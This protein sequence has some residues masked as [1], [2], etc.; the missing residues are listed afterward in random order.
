VRTLVLLVLLTGTAA[1]A[2]LS[3]AL[4]ETLERHGSTDMI[5]VWT[6]WEEAPTASDLFRLEVRGARARARS[7]WL[8]GISVQVPV[9]CVSELARVEGIRSLDRVMTGLV[10]EDAGS[11]LPRD[12]RT[13]GGM[14]F[15]YG[16]G[17]EQITVV[18]AD[19]V[20][21]EGF[22]GSGVTLG[23]FDTGY[24]STHPSISHLWERGAIAGAH[25][26]NS[27]DHIMTPFGALL[28]PFSGARYVNSLSAAEDLD[29][30]VVAFSVAS[31]ESI[32]GSSIRPRNK[33][34]M[35]YACDTSGLGFFETFRIAPGDSFAIQPFA[36]LSGDTLL[37]AWQSVVPG[38]GIDVQFARLALG[39]SMAQAT[40]LS[41][42]PEDAVDPAVVVHGD[43]VWVFWCSE[44]GVFVRRSTDFG[45]SYEP[46]QTALDRHGDPL[47][48]HASSAESVLMAA[49]SLGDSLVFLR[50]EDGGLV[51]EAKTLGSG[52]LPHFV[53]VDSTVHLIATHEDDLIYHRSD[54]LGETFTSLGTV[55]SET[56]PTV[57]KLRQEGSALHLV[58][59]S[60]G[61][62]LLEAPLSPDGSI[63]LVDILD[64]IYSSQPE[65]SGDFLAW[66]RRGDDDVSIWQDGYVEH[67]MSFRYHGTKV[68]SVIA[69]FQEGE[70]VGPAL[71]SDVLLAKTEKTRTTEGRGFENQVEE[72]FW[73]E[74]LEWSAE[75]GA[76]VVSSSLG[77][78]PEAPW[79]GWYSRDDFDGSTAISSKA[80][81][82]AAERGVVVVSAMGNV[83]HT[84]MPDPAVGDTTVLAPADAHDILAAGGYL[85]NESDQ[86]IVHNTSYGPSSDGRVKPEIIAP[87]WV[88]AAADTILGGET[89]ATNYLLF[90]GTS[91]ST[92]V[93]AGVCAMIWE[94]HPSWD[95]FDLIEAVINSAD[96]VPISG[97]SGASVPNY[98]EGYGL[99]DA[100]GAMHSEPLEVPAVSGDAILAPYPNPFDLNEHGEIA[101]PVVLFHASFVTLRIY[102]LSGEKVFEYDAGRLYPGRGEDHVIH[103]DGT[104]DAGNRVA[105]GVYLA[106][107]KTGFGSSVRK[108]AVVE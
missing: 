85:T 88:Y 57:G 22:F 69:G 45:V 94:A 39:D 17:E 27:G 12:L 28:L 36:A 78:G 105:P 52:A 8:E 89:E 86:L 82:M 101:F 74:A 81:S 6:F 63:G 24:D 102:T 106:M 46:V 90:A 47:G 108:F 104:N 93:T 66:R 9:F 23:V 2:A 95:A 50:S 98:V 43:T 31:E 100:Y 56:Y 91:Y 35:F 21:E 70:L 103:W 72:D 67:T 65:V 58:Y 54:D 18:R 7:M 79:Q 3:P 49:L 97:Y 33:W 60:S 61:G 16:F 92:A 59:S 84:S 30:R 107:L 44:S 29:K 62:S 10:Q 68:L 83:G 38:S 55:I 48:L 26:F 71:G 73:V 5:P 34:A 53:A 75:N 76:K 4:T 20:H 41:S 80:A 19:E 37:L 25:D 42:D 87:Y 14:E 11:D 96:P 1:S 64:G 99:L 40:N 15:N 51:F 13:L 32:A 77:Y